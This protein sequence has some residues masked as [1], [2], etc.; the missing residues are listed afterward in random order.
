[1]DDYRELDSAR[2][3]HLYRYLLGRLAIDRS[4][5]GDPN[6]QHTARRVGEKSLRK[7]I[8]AVLADEAAWHETIGLNSKDARLTAGRVAEMLGQ[9]KETLAAEYKDYDLHYSRVLTPEDILVALHHLTELAPA[10]RSRLGLPMGDKLT[11]LKQTLLSLQ[12]KDGSANYESIF[13]AYKESVGLEFTSSETTL[14]NLNQVNDLIEQSVRTAL[15][16]LPNRAR[17]FHKQTP[18]PGSEDIILELSRKAQREVR[19]LLVR[20]GNT[21]VFLVDNETKHPF[22]SHYLPPAFIKKFSQTIVSNERLTDQLPVYLKQVTIQAR[23]PLPFSDTGLDSQQCSNTYPRLLNPYLQELEGRVEHALIDDIPSPSDYELASQG[24]TKLTLSFYIKIDNSYESVVPDVFATL[25]SSSNERNHSCRRVDFDYSSTGIG[26]TLSHIIKVIN[27]TLIQDIACLSRFF[28]IVRD[29][30]STQT[31]I[32]DNVSSPIWAHSLVKLCHNRAVGEALWVYEE[33]KPTSSEDFSF[34]DPIGHGDFCGFDFF[35]A[36]AQSAV[37]ARLQAILN[38]GVNPADYIQQLCEKVERQLTLKRAWQTLAYYPFSSMGMIGMI[39]QKILKDQFKHR[40][41]CS[42]DSDVYFAAFLSITEALLDEGAYRAAY[43]NLKKLE[44]LETYAL[45]SLAPK[46]SATI[47]TNRCEIFSSQLIIRY[48]LCKATYYY[49]YDLQG[50]IA[51]H[52]QREFSAQVTRQQ[53]VEKAWTILESAQEHVKARLKK[54]LVVGEVSQGTFSPHYK[55]LSRIYLLRARLLTFF[56]RSVPHA[57]KRLPTENFSGQQRTEASVH[58]GKLYLLEKARLYIAA[59]GDGETYAYYAALQSCYYLTTAYTDPQ[60]LTL[61]DPRSGK[62]HTLSYDHCLTWAKRLRD[63]ALLAYARTGRLCYNAIKEKSGQPEEFDE[64]GRYRIEKLPAIFEDRGLQKGRKTSDNNEFLT[65]DISLL[66]IKPEHL[67]H[68]T[69]N[70]PNQTVYLFGTN[71]CHIFLAR[72]LYLLCSNDNEEFQGSGSNEQTSK[73]TA[74]QAAEQADEQI[75]WSHKLELA[76]R[77]FDLAWAIAEDGCGL[78]RDET[79]RQ[80]KNITRTFN[81]GKATDQ[82]TSREI[83]SVR[84]LYP[85]RVSEVADIGKIFSVAC[86]VLKLHLLPES[87]RPPIVEDIHKLFAMIHGEYRLESKRFLQALLLRQ[88]R[89]NGHLEA[90]LSSAQTVLKAYIPES[91]APATPEEMQTHRNELMQALF[92]TLLSEGLG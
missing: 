56:P 79:E 63:H 12:I 24:V 30:A 60:Q 42:T 2:S 31:I 27:T 66:A 28:P 68:I 67:S 70:P 44:L 46:N 26:G 40:A 35:I 55:L 73:Q 39:H 80:R 52:I 45:E 5:K 33:N 57:G 13:K 20:S 76:G 81:T 47:D 29:V 7:I 10:E 61:S 49:L 18:E 9:L 15:R 37:Q 23:G 92:A 71:A 48:L 51:A 82:Y 41:L 65:L 34:G 69:A 38:T 62:T 14:E 75:N 74:E 90:F 3:Y 83:D 36:Q 89:Y 53:L 88:S 78:A 58:W 86:M 59:E 16:H 17:R 64:Y 32:R 43:H 84:D 25:A 87:K 21:Q 72:G 19:R 8:S 4:D 50:P 22:I 77:L 11:L 91:T 1:M 85:R 6:N 54:Y